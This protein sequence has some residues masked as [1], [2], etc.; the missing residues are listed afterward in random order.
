MNKSNGLKLKNYIVVV[1]FFMMLICGAVL[2]TGCGRTNIPQ[3]NTGPSTIR[4]TACAGG[5]IRMDGDPN[6]FPKRSQI[7]EYGADAKKVF[8]V[9]DEGYYFVKWSDGVTSFVRSDKNVTSDLEFTAE[10]TPI[11]DAVTVVYSVK[12][13]G[14]IRGNAKQTIQ[15]GT[16]AQPVE[17]ILFGGAS[18]LEVFVRW[19]D[20][21]TDPNRQD[22]NI[23]ES[24]EVQAEFGFKLNYS[25]IGNGLIVGKAN[26]II[27][28][29]NYAETV[30]ALPDKGYRFVKWSDGVKTA[31]RTD[32]T[33][34]DVSA[35]FE[36]RDTDIFAYNFNYATDNCYEDGLTLTRGESEGKTA[37]VPT[38]GEYFTFCG[39]YLDEN[40]TVKAFDENGNSVL[41]EDIFNSPSRNLYAKWKAKEEY[42]T[43][44]KILMV[45]V[46]QINGTFIGNNG[47]NVTVNYSMD[48]DVRRQCIE[49]TKRF[50]DTLNGMLD[51]LVNFE[52]QS[53][54]TTKSIDEKCFV[55]EENNTRIFA[56]QIPELNN[57]GILDKYRSVITS[58]SFGGEENLLPHWAGVGDNKYA[59]IPIDKPI[60]LYGSIENALEHHGTL[61][62]FGPIIGT[63]VHEFIHTVEF[64]ITCYEFHS[65]YNNRLGS[66]ILYKLFLLNQFPTDFYNKLNKYELCTKENYLEAWKNSD[67][68][69]IPYSYWTNE[70]CEVTIKPECI[71]GRTDTDT[72]GGIDDITG[73][74]ANQD[75]WYSRGSVGN[76]HWI[77]KG[78]RSSL[79]SAESKRGY[80]FIGWSD[81]VKDEFRILTD[82]QDNITLI[83]Y[84]ER[85][86][87]TVEYI[88]GEGG[89]IEGEAV[90]T[91]FT[92]DYTT[93]VTAVPDEG[94]RFVGWS[95]NNQGYFN[96]ATNEIRR[97]IIGDNVY[98]ENGDFYHRLGFSVTAIFEKIE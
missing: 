53:Y 65:V 4:Y 97:D 15:R 60:K 20:G 13:Y 93:W 66:R 68:A 57:S 37:T 69:G 67:K 47:Q 30:T 71:N 72:G 48:A 45:Y 34:L 82:V 90:Q 29:G 94:Y 83:A 92:G 64:S 63:C 33:G 1:I 27:I 25:V 14:V 79:F 41:G 56:N 70:I 46:T 62:H 31:T 59:A 8:A 73:H 18:P 23:T 61:E 17:A 26:Q 95:D 75:W 10:F 43:T 81:G 36:W 88:A 85:L 80:R 11:T 3:K 38:R 55:N 21:L 42:V 77:P 32:S 7:V 49:L 52:V 84:F 16:E 98:N 2:F 24:M 91:A 51:G 44:Y 9:P 86:S 22:I 87:Y 19:S 39:W 6:L 54:F 28:Y 76:T 5:S 50:K 89:R 40:Y 58:Y 96:G 35:I 12:G 78:S 74:F